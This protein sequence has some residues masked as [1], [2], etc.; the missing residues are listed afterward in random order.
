MPIHLVDRLRE[1]GYRLTAQRRVVAEVLDGENLHLTADEVHKRAAELL[2]EISRATVYNTVQQ[3]AELGEVLELS[4]NGRSKHYDPNVN[5]AHHHLICDRC[6]LVYDVAHNTRAPQL[7]ETE[8]H[9]M[10]VE[11]TEIVYHATCAACH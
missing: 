10:V 9:D 5:P 7:D 8:L 3:F 2:P 6:G 1:R 11:R 4:L